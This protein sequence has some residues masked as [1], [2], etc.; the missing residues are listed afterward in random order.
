MVG[1]DITTGA[2]GVG[3]VTVVA[4][5]AGVGSEV[6]QLV[7]GTGEETIAVGTVEVVVGLVTG[8]TNITENQSSN[9]C[10]QLVRVSSLHYTQ[11]RS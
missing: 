4:E 9:D 1:N 6:G 5:T 3:L 11:T 2:D 8:V 7:G 10:S